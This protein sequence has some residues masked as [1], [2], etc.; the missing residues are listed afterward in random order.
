MLR[1]ASA[2]ITPAQGIAGFHWPDGTLR[3]ATRECLVSQ[4][5][6]ASPAAAW[7]TFSRLPSR[8]PA[9]WRSMSS[10]FS[11]ARWIP[12]SSEPARHSTPH[13][14]VPQISQISRLIVCAASRLQQHS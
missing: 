11:M 7:R 10:Y 13:F 5:V 9:N 2:D 1:P 12:I 4:A 14:L 3:L 6:A 8:L